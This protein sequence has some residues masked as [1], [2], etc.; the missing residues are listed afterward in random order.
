MFRVIF[1]DKAALILRNGIV[2][3]PLRLTLSV[4]AIRM[5]VGSGVYIKKG[6]R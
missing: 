1:S 6:E 5:L 3:T 2:G 4:V